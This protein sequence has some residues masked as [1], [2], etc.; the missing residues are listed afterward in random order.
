V[1]ESVNQYSRSQTV[2]APADKVFAFVSEIGNL[3]KYL[4][5]IT[6]A[7]SAGLEQVKLRG[8]I[9]DQG[10]FEGDGYYRVQPSERRMEWGANLGRDYSRRLWGEPQGD[11]RSEVTVEL[12][13]GPRSVDQ[14]IQ[15]EAG[16]DR[17]PAQEALAATLESIRRQVEGDGGKVAPPPP[18]PA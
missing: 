16:S 10:T 4:P 14:E 18:P 11:E 17:N 15:E 9:P 8:E 12:E 6:S 5:P 7:E 2:D 3:P 13:F 1:S